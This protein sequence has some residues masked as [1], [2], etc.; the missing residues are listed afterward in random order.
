MAAKV[1]LRVVKASRQFFRA[2]KLCF[3]LLFVPEKIQAIETTE[4]EREQEMTRE[5]RQ[6]EIQRADEE[7]KS[8]PL[9]VRQAF[10]RSFSVVVAAAVIGWIIGLVMGYML[11]CATAVVIDVLQVAGVGILLWGTLFVRGW[12]IQTFGGNTVT[13]RVNRWLYRSLYFVGTLFLVGA[14]SWYSCL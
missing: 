11:G 12:E 4:R 10:V 7:R 9:V 14:L 5:E 13:E 6:Q 2:A 3:F 1:F 8:A